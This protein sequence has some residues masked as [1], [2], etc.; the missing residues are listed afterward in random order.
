MRKTIFIFFLTITSISEVF[1]QKEWAPIGAKWYIN[2]G[3][4]LELSQQPL[5]SFFV[6]ESKK[7][8]VVNGKTYR[9]VGDYLMYQ[10]GYNV[11]YLY[12]DT[13]RLLYAFDLN[14][15]DTVTFN[16]LSCDGRVLNLPYK[17]K[18]V[19]SIIIGNDTLKRTFCTI[20]ILDRDYFPP[21]YE[22][23]EKIGSSRIVVEYIAG[24]SWVPGYYPEWLRCYIDHEIDYKSEIF[25][26]YGN[27][28]CDYKEGVDFIENID[29]I[30][31]NLLP[32]P[33]N[34]I[35]SIQNNDEI[36]KLTIYGIT[37][38]KILDILNY[39]NANSIDVTVL[40]NGMYILNIVTK[41]GM[42]RDQLFVKN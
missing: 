34:D 3:Y 10:D 25:L 27:Y 12:Q 29:H 7:D 38:V 14:V 24:C 33:V 21:V 20:E 37:G 8:T 39:D 30:D 23:F 16:L 22:Y 13:L 6:V 40:K 19:D 1:C 36:N 11:Y 4:D 42:R 15:G 32:N 41:N 17:V 35:L 9:L 18:E 2:A 5:D 26:S 28:E 31:F